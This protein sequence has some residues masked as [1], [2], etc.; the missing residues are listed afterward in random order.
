MTITFMHEF[1]MMGLGVII[2]YKLRGLISL[3]LSI[4]DRAKEMVMKMS[5]VVGVK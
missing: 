1:I 4:V 3:T 2:G 5:R